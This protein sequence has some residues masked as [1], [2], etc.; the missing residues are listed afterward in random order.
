MSAMTSYCLRTILILVAL[1]PTLTARS[2]SSQPAAPLTDV[3]VKGESS[4][5]TFRIPS[6]LLTSKG[7]LLAF[8]EARRDS[9]RDGGHTEIALKRSTDGGKSWGPMAIIAADPPNAVCNPCAVLERQTGTIFLLHTRNL[10]SDSEKAILSG[11]SK[12]TCT[13]WVISSTDDGVT[14]SKPREIT[15]D[16]KDK[17]WTWYATGP[18]VGIQLSTGRLII[19]CNDALAGSKTYQSHTIYSD[20]HGATWKLGGVAGVLGN[21]SQAVE[22]SDGSVMTNM[23]SYRGKHC[24]A[25]SVSK[26]GGQTWSEV[27]DDPMLVEPVCQASITRTV[28]DG[29]M[30][31][32]F[33]NPADPKARRNL[34]LRTSEDDGKTWPQS[35]VLY[36]G[37]AA[38]SCLAA[39]D[40]G[41]VACLF[42]ADD[43]ARIVLMRVKF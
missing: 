41:T 7:T 11:T 38:Y 27:R 30:I 4:Y 33:S 39:L 15:A 8:A 32:L 25:V 13:V 23:R 26:D 22:L 28:R 40:D 5:N 16:V 6:L 10:G 43:H 24:R 36:P 18:G 21:E 34:T 29:K 17:N 9:A 20:D 3:Y 1:L 2:Q 35:M 14:W 42:E 12:G 31:L 37:S 19:P